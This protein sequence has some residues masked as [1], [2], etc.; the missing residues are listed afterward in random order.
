MHR[1]FGTLRAGGIDLHGAFRRH[2]LLVAL[3]LHLIMGRRRTHDG[4]GAIRMLIVERGVLLDFF[5]RD[6]A[7]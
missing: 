4:V 7:L 6:A 2:L 1:T 3:E 5:T